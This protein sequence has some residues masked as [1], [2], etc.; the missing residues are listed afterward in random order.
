[1]V[2]A[3]NVSEDRR[4]TYELDHAEKFVNLTKQPYVMNYNYL[5]RRREEM[6]MH[7]GHSVAMNKVEKRSGL[8]LEEFWD[9][10]DGKW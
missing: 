7:Y 9:L 2:I 1:M 6:L 10:Y 5:Q 8:S 4:F 3:F